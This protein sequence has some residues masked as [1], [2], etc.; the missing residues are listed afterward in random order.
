M[1]VIADLL[2][3]AHLPLFAVALVVGLG[4]AAASRDLG[5]RLLGAGVAAFAGVVELAVLTRDDPSAA[6]G[7]LAA[8]ILAFGGA[9]LGLALLVR[10]REGFG[11]VDAGGL[12]LAER[13]DDGVE[14]GE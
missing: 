7:A 2:Q 14:R 9:T 8:S 13:A 11:G 3:R 5:K 6:N 12:Q 10:V 1:I 4:L